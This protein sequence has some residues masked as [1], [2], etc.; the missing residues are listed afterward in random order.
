MIFY[1]YKC[2]YRVGHLRNKM[3]HVEHKKSL[4]TYKKYPKKL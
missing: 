4:D 2:S 3:F 1:N